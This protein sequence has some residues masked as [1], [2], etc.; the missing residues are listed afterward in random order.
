MGKE[1]EGLMSDLYKRE[2][3][4]LIREKHELIRKLE[5][6]T[7]LMR[8]Y[9]SQLTAKDREVPEEKPTK[10][11]SVRKKTSTSKKKTDGS[12]KTKRKSKPKKSD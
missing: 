11:K 2:N 1:N 7:S 9:E 12:D 5:N 3:E 4:K 8:E 6:V 10:K